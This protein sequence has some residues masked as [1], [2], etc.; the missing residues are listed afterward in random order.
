[1]RVA[2]N[3]RPP[4]TARHV[5]QPRSS[6]T[7]PPP[8]TRRSPQGASPRHGEGGQLGC[9]TVAQR[10][11]ACC[12][13]QPGPVVDLPATAAPHDTSPANN[14]RP[15]EMRTSCCQ[16]P[17]PPQCDAAKMSPHISICPDPV[18]AS[19]CPVPACSWQ[20]LP[21]ERR[22]RSALG[23]R[24]FPRFSFSSLRGLAFFFV[25]NYPTVD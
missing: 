15:E 22:F 11:K 8:V 7:P 13:L 18:L 1:M 21:G 19:P 14:N 12:G 6:T 4:P 17:A 5:L 24:G 25:I 2:P 3:C 10:H 20:P 16:Q 9:R 23:N